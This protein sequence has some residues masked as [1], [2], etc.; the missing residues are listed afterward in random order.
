[1]NRKA[2][3]GIIFLGIGLVWSI[4]S[5]FFIKNARDMSVL[6]GIVSLIFGVIL[7]IVGFVFLIVFLMNWK[8]TVGI[9]FLGIGL[10]WSILSGFIIINAYGMLKLYGILYL[11]ISVFLI[12][13]GFVFL[14]VFL[15]SSRKREETIEGKSRK[16][17]KM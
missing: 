17:N 7:I 15:I 4:L 9:I 14:I 2:T 10:V 8:A 12:I 11:I 13:V 3:A 5:G 1:M 6:N 16:I